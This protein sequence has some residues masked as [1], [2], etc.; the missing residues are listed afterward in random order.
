ML[1][2]LRPALVMIVALTAITGLAYPLAMTGVAGALFPHQANGSLIVENGIVIGS[3]RIGQNFTAERYFHGRPSVTLGPDPAD[4]SKTTTVPYNAVNSMGS[5]AGPGNAA[6]IERVK[7]DVERL[8][9]ENPSLP[10]P[11][12]LVTSTG[13]GL[14]PH[15]SPDAALF[16]VPRVAKARSVSEDRIRALVAEHTESRLLGILGEPRVNV[17]ALNRALDG[18]VR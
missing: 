1:K 9:A 8:K 2:Q 10:V 6:L 7:A 4:P 14:D 16:Q 15:I 11:I 13:S 3:E 18:T 17:L 12:D 5:N